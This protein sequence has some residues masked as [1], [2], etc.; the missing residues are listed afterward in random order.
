MAPASLAS[1]TSRDSRSASLADLG[2][3][4]RLAVEHAA[5]DDQQR[6]RLGEVTQ[7]LGGLDRVA[8]DEGDGGRAGEQVVERRRRRPPW[9]R[10]WSACSSPRRSGVSSPSAR[11]SSL[12]CSTVRP[13]YSVST[14]AVEL[15]KLLGQL[16]D[17]GCLVGPSPWASFRCRLPV[18][19][20]GTRATQENAPAQAHGAVAG[21]EAA[22]VWSM[23]PARAAPRAAEPSVARHGGGD[24]QRSSA[25]ARDVRASAPARGPD[26]GRSVTASARRTV[27]RPRRPSSRGERRWELRPRRPRP[28]R[29]GCGCGW[30]RPGCRGPSSWRRRPS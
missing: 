11:R 30:G 5:L 25:F 4:Q 2:G 26:S 23:S 12:S 20:D 3:G 21:S 15:R 24:D 28:R 10:S 1:S 19:R 14:V 22:G 6:V 13:R 27:G 17:G 7:A 9:R 29:A 16:G 8:L 18:R